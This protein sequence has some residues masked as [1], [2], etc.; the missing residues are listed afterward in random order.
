MIDLVE[1]AKRLQ[2][3]CERNNWQFAFIGGLALQT[4]GEPRVTEDVDITLLTGFGDEEVFIKALLQNYKGR[5]TNVIEFALTNRVLLLVS[6]SGVEVDISLGALPFEESVVKR[7][8][9]KNYLPLVELRICS[10]EDLIVL[11][12]FADR[13]KDWVDIESVLIKQSK[14][15]WKYIKRQLAPLVELK[16]APEILVKLEKMRESI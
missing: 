2:N 5:I 10:A 16:D 4:W 3:V 13:G 11:K 15:D 6:E 7:A 8:V 14:L 1:E 9:Y 12:A